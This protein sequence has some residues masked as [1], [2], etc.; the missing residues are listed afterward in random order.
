MNTTDDQLVSNIKQ[1]LNAVKGKRSSDRAK[2]AAGVES[3][4]LRNQPT[5]ADPY[6]VPLA[7][8]PEVARVDLGNVLEHVSADLA[9]VL[10][11]AE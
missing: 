3:R 6:R 9:G 10:A 11:A 4:A 1:L 5:M 2:G 7:D 8:R